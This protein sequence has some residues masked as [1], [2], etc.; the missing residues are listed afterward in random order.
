MIPD[1][2]VQ[3]ANSTR[4]YN[5][6]SQFRVSEESLLKIM[7]LPTFILRVQDNVNS[8][9]FLIVRDILVNNNSMLYCKIISETVTIN[10]IIRNPYTTR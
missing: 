6:I 3:C 10:S 1:K 9:F 4:D 5:K 8:F 2:S 7:A